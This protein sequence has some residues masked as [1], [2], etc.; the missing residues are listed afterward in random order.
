MHKHEKI[1]NWS[2]K[3]CKIA[4][5]SYSLGKR[6]SEEELVRKILRSMPIDF[7]LKLQ[8]LKNTVIWAPRLEI[9]WLANLR[10][11]RLIIWRKIKKKSISFQ[12]EMPNLESD[13]NNA[14]DAD[15]K[16]K[17]YKNPWVS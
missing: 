15:N 12:A 14:L 9:K 1:T 3:L 6:I 10:L 7:S 16:V 11:L 2:A 13:V 8:L 5:T 17:T 4:N